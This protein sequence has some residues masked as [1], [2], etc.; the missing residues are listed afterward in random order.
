MD[1]SIYDRYRSALQIEG[2]RLLFY[3]ESRLATRIFLLHV[4]S[5]AFGINIFRVRAVR[6]TSDSK[7]ELAELMQIFALKLNSTCIFMIL[8]DSTDSLT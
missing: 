6:S 5:S 2:I 8:I 1:S 4:I 3:H 7:I